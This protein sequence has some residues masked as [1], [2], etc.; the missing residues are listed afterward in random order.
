MKRHGKL[1]EQITDI[2]TI[3][4]AFADAKRGKM[5]QA[6]VRRLAENSEA[7]CAS[8]R[9]MLVNKT[10]TT[11]PYRTMWITEPK[12]REIF[13][14]PFYP[15]RIVHHALMHVLEP[16]WSGLFIADSYACLPGKGIHAASRRTMEFVRKYKYCLKM[17]ISKFYPSVDHDIMYAIIQRKIK[18]LDALWLLKNIIYSV[19]N[20]KNVPI[21][22][23]TSQWMG[24][25][26]LNELDHFIKH[27][28]H[29]KAYIRY[30]D[31]F[32]IFTMIK[33]PGRNGEG[34]RNISG[35][36]IEITNEQVRS[37]SGKPGR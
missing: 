4:Q 28:H 3:R 24:N 25:L 20:G 36:K 30:C 35:G 7:I 37:I 13:C 1:F 26:Y 14:L 27:D 21:G 12:K 8:I 19:P 32:L 22:N 15:D 16:I 6:S 29:V 10:F 18:C 17:D 9:E 34:H 31:D 11:S 23:Y 2:E 5:N 33:I